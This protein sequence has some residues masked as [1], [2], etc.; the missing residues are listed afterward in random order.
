MPL[1]FCCLVF[2]VNRICHDSNNKYWV[3]TA[4][5]SSIKIWDLESKSIVVDL[6]IDLKA[7]A[8]M[9]AEGNV[10]QTNAGKNKVHFFVHFEFEF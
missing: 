4:T 6:R 7:E 2:L 10:T 3:C 1:L 8:D 9:A 5:E